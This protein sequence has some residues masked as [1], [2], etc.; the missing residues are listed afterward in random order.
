MSSQSRLSAL[1]ENPDT[2]RA[3]MKWTESEN[4]KLMERAVQGMNIDE[5]AKAHMRTVTGVKS[6][7]MS[8]ALAMM[9]H[10]DMTIEDVSMHVHIPLEELE[11][12]KQ[13]EDEKPKKSCIKHEQDTVTQQKHNDG[14]K[15]G[16][17]WTSEEENKLIEEIKK[18]DVEEI[19]NVHQRTVGGINSR[20][21]DI[22][23]RWLQQGMEIHNVGK[24]LNLSEK[25]LQK[26]MNMRKNKNATQK[27]ETNTDML[28][29]LREIRDLLKVIADK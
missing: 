21:R 9:E 16:K 4:T 15:T 29:I 11:A 25:S 24:M 23:C 10:E 26:S 12:Y 7:I 27:D 6:R 13:R 3:G 20:L 17:A 8:N 2:A 28:T 14:E 19:A 1:R 18:L 22:G 5:I